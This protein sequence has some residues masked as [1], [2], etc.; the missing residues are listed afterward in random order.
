MIG[1]VIK[2]EAEAKRW[3]HG[4]MKIKEAATYLSI[5]TSTLRKMVKEDKIPYSQNNYGN[6][7]AFFHQAILEAWMKGE[8]PRGRVELILDNE[9]IEYDHQ[10]ALREH[11][12]RYP[13]LLPKSINIQA[14]PANIGSINANQN[15]FEVCSDG[16]RITIQIG[17]I[18][19]QTNLTHAAI[20]ELILA[21]QHFRQR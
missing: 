9:K 13:E 10:D 5:S 11:Y 12:E 17:N 4:Y 3:Y 7:S 18:M 6:N 14:T 21:V 2:G 19:M 1:Y 8:F 16:I 20:D 15:M